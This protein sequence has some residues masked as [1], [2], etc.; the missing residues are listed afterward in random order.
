MSVSLRFCLQFRVE[1]LSN[2]IMCVNSMAVI[3]ALR[4]TFANGHILMALWAVSGSPWVTR[5]MTDCCVME[6]HR[7][8]R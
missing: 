6:L 7:A 5:D 1:S 8:A 4:L 2:L 3:S